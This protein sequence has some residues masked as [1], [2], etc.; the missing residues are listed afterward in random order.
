MQHEL[1]GTVVVTNDFD[2]RRTARVVKVEDG[3]AWFRFDDGGHCL[4]TVL[5]SRLLSGIACPCGQE[6]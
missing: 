4:G 6:H 2:I 5:V 3:V 1:I